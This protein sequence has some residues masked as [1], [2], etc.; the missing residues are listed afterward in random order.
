M[1]NENSRR[2]KIKLNRKRIHQIETMT[3][4]ASQH[5]IEQAVPYNRIPSK[6]NSNCEKSND[7]YSNM[8]KNKGKIEIK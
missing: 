4:C 5:T 8:S 1:H 2:K 6:R 7:R 3:E